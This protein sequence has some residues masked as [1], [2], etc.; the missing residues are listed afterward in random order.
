MTS[1][2][3]ESNLKKKKK[4]HRKKGFRFVVTRDGVGREEDEEF[5]KG[6]QN[7]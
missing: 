1:L 5:E 3:V 2:Y 4:T 7:A 6:N